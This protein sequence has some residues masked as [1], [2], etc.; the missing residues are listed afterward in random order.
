M[1]CYIRDANLSPKEKANKVQST[2]KM[3]QDW[4]DRQPNDTT[5]D[6]TDADTTNHNCIDLLHKDIRN[7]QIKTCKDARDA[8]A[9]LFEMM[10][11]YEQD[12]NIDHRPDAASFINTINAW[13]YTRQKPNNYRKGG[14]VDDVGG[15]GGE[16]GVDSDN[17][18]PPE[19]CMQLLDILAELYNVEQE[20]GR[21]VSDIKPDRR[22]YNAVQIVWSRSKTAT[23]QA[24]QT[25]QLL[26]T[27]LE[28]YEETQDEDYKPILRQYN[29]VLNVCVYTSTKKKRRGKE[30]GTNNG[31]TS[32]SPQEQQEDEK[33]EAMKIL[34]ETFNELRN[35]GESS[36]SS[37]SSV[38]PN[39]VSY[40]L[41]LKGCGYLLSKEEQKSAIIETVFRK[42]C[43]DGY[44]SEFVLEALE[45]A[46]A[47]SLYR[48]LLG[49]GSGSSSANDNDNDNFWDEDGIQIPHEWARHT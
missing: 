42:C 28:K 37:S 1:S 36:S 15:S 19:C 25:K 35:S 10:D 48:K 26:T 39:H 32:T 13:K 34:V 12:L 43:R 18:P 20:C 46:S 14:A 47:P 41:F 44:V 38:S 24:Y 45:Q 31:S 3:M 21:D 2:I 17:A 6:T 29:N 5:T 4:N 33:K 23:N 27:L 11:V 40:G 49:G 8:E 16:E 7:I 22:V 9:I 30:D